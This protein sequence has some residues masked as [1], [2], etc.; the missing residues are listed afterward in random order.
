MKAEIEIE[1]RGKWINL[2]VEFEYSEMRGV[3]MVDTVTIANQEII[4]LM[5]E[6]DMDYLNR[7]AQKHLDHMNLCHKQ[8]R[9]ARLQRES[10]A[11]IAAEEQEAALNDPL[12][13]NRRAG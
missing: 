4:E 1:F 5:D 13:M 3:A 11:R 10:F 2:P 9:E 12:K 6:Q 7:I 8:S